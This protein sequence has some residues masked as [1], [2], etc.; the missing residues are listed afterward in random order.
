MSVEIVDPQQPVTVSEAAA[1]HFRDQCRQAEAGAVY[2]SLK[3]SGCTG[4][5]Y[6]LDLVNAAPEGAVALQLPD[7]IVLYLDPGA[8]PVLRGT[9][10]DYVRKGLNS[11][12]Q[13]QNPNAGD[14]CG[15]GESFNVSEGSR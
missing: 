7:D 4:Y 10:I 2:L 8:L 13:F 14:Y 9:V 11:E 3:R 15:C 12:L 6:D 5:M 1:R